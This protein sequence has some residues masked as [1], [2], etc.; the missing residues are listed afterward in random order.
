MVVNRSR[1][2]AGPL[3][4][5]RPR[6]PGMVEALVAPGDSSEFFARSGF[7][8]REAIRFGGEGW[9]RAPSPD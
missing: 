1:A 8:L 5:L 4:S 9:P 2:S 7:I 3:R 6:R